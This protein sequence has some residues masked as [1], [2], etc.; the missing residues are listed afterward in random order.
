M[1]SDRG[2]DSAIGIEGSNE[3]FRFLEVFLRDE[4]DFVDDDDVAEFELVDHEIT[5]VALVLLRDL[6]SRFLSIRKEIGRFEVREDV[7]S[8]DHCNHCL[9]K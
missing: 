2:K 7:E 8:V 6:G 5:D 9:T 3:R 1:R 4:V